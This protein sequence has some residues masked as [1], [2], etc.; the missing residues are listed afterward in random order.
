MIVS[1]EFQTDVPETLSLQENEYTARK[2]KT[3]FYSTQQERRNAKL[4]RNRSSLLRPRLALC[5]E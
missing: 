2:P 3:R 4:G 1:I 5:S